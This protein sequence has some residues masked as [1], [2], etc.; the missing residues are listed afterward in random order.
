MP[1]GAEGGKVDPRTLRKSSSSR[2][3]RKSFRLDYRLEVTT[4]LLLFTNSEHS[5]LFRVHINVMLYLR[6]VYF[7]MQEEVTKSCRDKHGRWTNPWPTWRFP[8]YSML[9]RF[10]VLDKNHSNVPTSKEVGNHLHVKPCKSLYFTV[11]NSEIKKKQQQC[12]IS[13]LEKEEPSL[14][15]LHLWSQLTALLLISIASSSFTAL[16]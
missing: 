7:S 8:S 5:S 10:L 11:D 2:S 6:C 13:G 16:S 1:Q 12:F 9:F 15:C 4:L 14:R 3:S